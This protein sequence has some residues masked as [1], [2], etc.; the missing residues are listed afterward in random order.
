MAAAIEDGDVGRLAELAQELI[1]V[2][3]GVVCLVVVIPEVERNPSRNILR[4][5]QKR[6]VGSR[7]RLS[8]LRWFQ[9]VQP[10]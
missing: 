10:P 6:R 7:G 4:R 9:R 2:L 5:L 3:H 8:D 1:P